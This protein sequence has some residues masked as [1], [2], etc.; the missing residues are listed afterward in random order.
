M[1]KNSTGP[2]ACARPSHAGV[3]DMG[4]LYAA[5]AKLHDARKA[6]GKRYA[7]ALVLLL[8]VLAK[9]CGEDLPLG[10]AQW[11]RAR[12]ETLIR[13]LGLKRAHLPCL[14]TYRRVLSD[15]VDSAELTEVVSQFLLCQERTG[16]YQSVAICIDGKT[17]RGTIPTGESRGVHLLAAYLPEEGIVLMQVAVEAGKE[18]EIT[19]APR[20]LSCLDLRGKVVM[21]DA[22]LTQ[23]EL[24]VQVVEG[25]GE[26]IWRVKENQPWALECL[27]AH[28]GPEHCVKGFSPGVTDYRCA[29]RYDKGHGRLENR[30][31]R[32]SSAL[33]GFLDWPHMEQVF[34]LQRD[35][36]H[37]KTG[38]ATHEE[39][40]GLTSLTAQEAGPERL[41]ELTRLYWE[42]ENGLHYRRD[43]TLREDATQTIAHTTLG[44]AMAIIN[45]LIV[46]MVLHASS[47]RYL[48]DARRHY[49]AHPD[50][51]LHL[52]LHT[53]V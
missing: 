7:L 14:N 24:S 48:P 37:T 8:V 11:V 13:A 49:D 35:A 1:E 18:N 17:L 9:L 26:Y 29:Q 45:N 42:I 23:R 10:I 6:R 3:F 27:Q 31:I 21:A 5:L 38:E 46:G 40:Y 28:F 16:G 53:P 41:L 50:E 4:S 39:V 43:K 15:A 22:M 44:Q 33:K 19:A 36:L 2:P 12:R 32:V 20:L 47:W 34:Q 52:L 51:A 30:Q 25:G